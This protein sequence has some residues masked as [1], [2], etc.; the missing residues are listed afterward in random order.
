MTDPEAV[1]AKMVREAQIGHCNCPQC[2][3]RYRA[4]D[5]AI[6]IARLVGALEQQQRG[7]HIVFGNGDE[8]QRRATE[9]IIFECRQERDRLL[10]EIEK[11]AAG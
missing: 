3:D 4:I 8:I 6:R 1:L 7:Y 10:R 5:R 9:L 2:G 11:E